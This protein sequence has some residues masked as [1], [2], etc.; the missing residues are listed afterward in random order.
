M[1]QISPAR[2]Y[3]FDAQHP[4]GHYL[5]DLSEQTH[6]DLASQLMIINAGAGA[7]VT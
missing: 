7:A 5:L 4:S 3:Y 6:F 2:R 1:L